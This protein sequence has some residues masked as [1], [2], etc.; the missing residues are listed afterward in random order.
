[1]SAASCSAQ[2]QQVRSTLVTHI[3]PDNIQQV[4]LEMMGKLKQSK[5]PREHSAAGQSAL[6]I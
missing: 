2:A 4:P 6:H 3:I 5:V 1:M